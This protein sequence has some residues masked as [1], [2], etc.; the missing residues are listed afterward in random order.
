MT[1][2]GWPLVELASR[3]LQPEEREA[4]L[5]DLAEVDESA[6]RGLLDVLGLFF[7]RQASLWK[8]ARPWL[9]GFGVALP[10]TFLLMN[11]SISVTCTY[12]RLVFHKTLWGHWPTGNEGYPL[13]LCHIFLLIAWSWTSG[14]VVGS[15]SRGTVWVSAALCAASSVFCITV[16]CIASPSFL[17]IF[18]FLPPAAVGALHGLRMARIPAEPA[19]ALALCVT[20][21]MISAWTNQAL[22]ILNWALVCPAWYLVAISARTRHARSTGSHTSSSVGLTA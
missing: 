1:M 15:I 4:V 12:Q 20:A 16:L 14:F 8:D 13:L 11:V 17:C 2:I 3:L 10:A 19:F 18:L 6:W 9:A 21:L 22:W 5:G 7:R